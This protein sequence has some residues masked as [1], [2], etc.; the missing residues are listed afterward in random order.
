[1]TENSR[2]DQRT[3]RL[4]ATAPVILGDYLR[5]TA[6][7]TR[8]QIR[9]L[10]YRPRG[11]LVNGEKKYVTYR[12]VPGDI[13]EVELESSAKEGKPIAL[14]PAPLDILYEDED[15]IAVNKAAGVP[16]HPAGMHQDDTLV[17]MLLYYFSQKQE[18]IRVRAAGRLDAATSGVI[19]FSKNQVAAGRLVRQRERKLLRKEYIAAVTGTLPQKTG[20]IDLPIHRDPDNVCRVII[21]DEGKYAV[22]HYQVLSPEEEEA[23]FRACPEPELQQPAEAASSSGV[24]FIRVRIDTGRMHQIRAH[25]AAIGHPLLGD[26]MYGGTSDL[27]GRAALHAVSLTFRQPF[28]GAPISLT[29]PLPED[30]R[31][32]LRISMNQAGDFSA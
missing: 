21:S 26:V 30:M 13:V 31:R 10:K 1:M 22:T 7:L 32:L 12:L 11:I 28:T 19:L 20:T 4:M 5:L 27:I 14:N 24:T 15:L 25:M 18:M 9:Q 17:N 6:G 16:T 2:P 23:L 3:L 8:R 29:A